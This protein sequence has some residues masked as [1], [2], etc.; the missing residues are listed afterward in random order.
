MRTLPYGLAVAGTASFMLAGFLV[1]EALGVPLL[2]APPD[3]FADGGLWAAP[4]GAALLVT[5]VL[6]PVPSSLVMTALGAIL[7]FAAGAVVCWTAGTGSALI[8]F[9]LGRRGVGRV[10]RPERIERMLAR[11]G[12]PA[13]AMTRPIPILAETTMIVAGLSPRVTWRQ[14]AIGAAAGALPA[15]LIYSAAGAW[16]HD[17]ASGAAVFAVVVALSGLAWLVDRRIRS[18]APLQESPTR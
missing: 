15:S 6:L 1:A 17:T 5:D 9:W 7:G 2:T 18:H 12:V 8:G 3:G 16:T 13:I 11:Y 10:A 4:V 14:A